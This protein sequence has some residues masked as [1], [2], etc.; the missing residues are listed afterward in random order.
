MSWYP[1]EAAMSLGL[2]LPHPPSKV[3][4]IRHSPPMTF[5]LGPLKGSGGES[6][7]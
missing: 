6:S 5:M 1:W 7:L 4:H 2:L 3:V